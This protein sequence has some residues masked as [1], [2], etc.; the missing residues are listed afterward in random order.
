MNPTA[1]FTQPYNRCGQVNSSQRKME[2]AAAI[3]AVRS[4]QAELVYVAPERLTKGQNMYIKAPPTP[5]SPGCCPPCLLA[6]VMCNPSSDRAAHPGRL[7]A[8]LEERGVSIM[9]VD[10]AHCISAWGHDFR[11]SYSKIGDAIKNLQP[12]R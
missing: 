7:T 8:A 4:G 3:S 12:V 9:A 5:P 1:Q 6:S 2:Q 10:E 11:P